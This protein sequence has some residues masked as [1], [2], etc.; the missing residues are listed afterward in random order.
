MEPRTLLFTDLDGTFLEHRT[1]SFETARSVL[2]TLRAIGIPVIFSTSKTRAEVEPL[3]RELGLCAPFIAENGAAVFIPHGIFP[4]DPP[5]AERRGAYDVIPF[6]AS[7]A[8]VVKHLDEV[9]RETG[10]ALLSFHLMTTDQIAAE[11][12][13]SLTAAA[14]AKMREFDVPFRLADPDP[15]AEIQVRAAIHAKGLSL[16]RGAH[17]FHLHLGCDKGGSA[18][19]LTDLYRKA[20]GEVRTVAI[21]DSENDLSLLENVLVAAIVR[22]EDGA[23]DPVLIERLPQAIRAEG[24]GPAGFAE[25]V[26]RLIA[27]SMR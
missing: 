15:E 18:R 13:L 5:N 11:T 26:K 24:I 20:W 16:T 25:V 12:G 21:G 23:H 3:Q 4:F 22:R 1:F 6:G 17:Y 14:H 9:E 2:P 10:V 19:A 8:S 27:G 7:Y